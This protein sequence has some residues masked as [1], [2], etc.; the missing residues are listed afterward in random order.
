MTNQ[1]LGVLI[2]V[3]VQEPSDLKDL[4]DDD[5]ESESKKLSKTQSKRFKV[6]LADFSK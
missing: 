5:I 3:G 2:N 6:E 4:D 1:A